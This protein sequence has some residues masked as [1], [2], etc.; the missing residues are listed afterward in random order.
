MAL[1]SRERTAAYR[2]RQKALGLPDVTR[3]DRVR[4]D[5]EYRKLKSFRDPHCRP[6]FVSLERPVLAQIFV[7]CDG[8]GA[9]VD[10]LGRQNY[11]LFRMGER[12]L[13]HDDGSPLTTEE[14]LDFICDAPPGQINVGFSFGYD[15]T[16]ILRDLDPVRLARIVGWDAEQETRPDGSTTIKLTKKRPRPDWN[17]GHASPYTWFK[18]FDIDYLPR[19]FFRVRR[20]YTWTD[21]AT[22]LERR[23]G[24]EKSTRTIFEVFGFFQK[25]FLATV[26]M[27]QLGSDDER[28]RL[29]INK[30]ARG[31]ASWALTDEVREYC[32][33]ECRLLGEAMEQLRRDC[34]DAGAGFVP[35]QWSGAGKIAKALHK[36]YQTPTAERVAE[37]VPERLL[38]FADDAFYGGRFET[39]WLGHVS[40]EG[41]GAIHEYDICSAYPAAMRSL[42]C[43]E[44][45]KWKRANAEQLTKAAKRGELY[46]AEVEFNL[47]TH[48]LGVMGGLP[49]RT[50]KGLLLWPCQGTGT[51]WGPEIESAK[52][53]G[54]RIKYLR[55]FIYEKRCTCQQFD[56]VERLYEY[57]KTIKRERGEAAAHPIKL[58]INALYGLLV[59]RVGKGKYRN[60]LWGG[61]ITAIVRAQINDA[62]AQAPSQ[63]VMIATDGIYSRVP[64]DLDLGD[65]LGQWEHKELPSLFVVQP[66]L[67]WSP[68]DRTKR[69]KIKTRGMSVKFFELPGRT[70]AFEQSWEKYRLDSADLRREQPPRLPSIPVQLT[71]FIGIALAIQRHDPDT[72]GQ[73]KA[74]TR[75]ITFDYRDKRFHHAWRDGGIITGIWAGDRKNKSVTHAQNVAS[76]VAET[77]DEFRVLLEDMQDA[78]DFGVPF[79][80]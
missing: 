52:R 53:L 6:E 33:L 38:K 15:V 68:Q 76:G 79:S 47:P 43:L 8:E 9:G 16:M 4:Q 51:Y 17:N 63:I 22:G 72:A 58:G 26:E 31:G 36:H 13:V 60:P 23:V 3:K 29:A 7:G 50:D 34:I 27:Y 42:P 39:P 74:E 10:T 67:Y 55:G 66:G 61:L 73:W 78:V 41:G 69:S 12:E 25:S 5:A 37:L 28:K 45:G 48:G 32:T 49:I 20:C 2:A 54:H 80:D 56:W 62:I 75:K 71:V 46:L 40:G 19:N 65:R 24:L 70:E 44:H 11:V 14:L 21:P 35:Q 77:L 30:A 64:L 1:S 18:A 57:R 59:Q